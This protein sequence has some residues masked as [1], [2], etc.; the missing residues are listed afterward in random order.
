MLKTITNIN[1]TQLFIVFTCLCFY[2]GIPKMNVRS[3]VR[4]LLGDVKYITGD[5]R[6]TIHIPKDCMTDTLEIHEVTEFT[7]KQLKCNFK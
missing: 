7:S 4:L 6:K 2:T 1:T 3:E 5:H